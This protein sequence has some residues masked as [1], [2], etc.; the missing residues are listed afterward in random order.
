MGIKL[1]IP[2]EHLP[3]QEASLM[4]HIAENS[5]GLNAEWVVG[6]EMETRL[7]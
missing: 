4:T 6:L 2:G 5:I 1:D 3:C 7:L